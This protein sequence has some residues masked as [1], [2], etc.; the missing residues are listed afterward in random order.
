MAEKPSYEELVLRVHQLE[1]KVAISEEKEGALQ[2][3]H[4]TLLTVLNSIDATIYVADMEPFEILF[5]NK[6]MIQSFGKDMV[7]ETCYK[8]FRNESG[9]CANCTNDKLIDDSGNPL[10][11]FNIDY[12]FKDGTLEGVR[13][14]A[15][16]ITE[17]KKIEI[18]RETLIE[19]LKT[20][21]D[22]IKTLKGIVPICSSCKKI[23]DDKGYWNLLE[24]YIEKHSNASF[25]HGMCPD[26][27]EKFYGNEGWYIEMKQKKEIK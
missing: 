8:V 5:N 13:C 23:R 26:C 22:E 18:E 21:L 20:A 9:Q 15:H 19:K 4:N 3:S 7:G 10:D 27:S 14:V 24:S 12:I 2:K 1:Q 16:D 25:S 6:Y 17:R 11:V